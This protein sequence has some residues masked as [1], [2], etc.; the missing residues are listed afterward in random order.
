MFTNLNAVYHDYPRLFW[1][2]VGI[3]FIDR[4]GGTMLFPFFAL[5]IT[6]KFDVGMMQAGFLLGM[7]SLFGLFG[8]MIGG[9]LTDRLGRKPLILFGLIFS[10]LST[11]T[12]GLVTE[13]KMMYH[14][15]SLS[16]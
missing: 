3:S 8:G 9:A 16:A 10:A 2:V 7:M 13:I 12:F 4:V 1:V 15:W 6:Q 14:W 11:L 5:Y